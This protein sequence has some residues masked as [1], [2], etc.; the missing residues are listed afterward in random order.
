MLFNGVSILT[1]GESLGIGTPPSL[2][3]GFE[4]LFIPSCCVIH[5]PVSAAG[6]KG[7][8]GK[9]SILGIALPGT[10]TGTAARRAS[11]LRKQLLSPTPTAEHTFLM[12]LSAHL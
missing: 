3:R 1:Q 11:K 7:T 5:G 2:S 10:V 8:P 4:V 12:A 6:A 9:A